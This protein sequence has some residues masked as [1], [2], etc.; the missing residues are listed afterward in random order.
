MVTEKSVKR[1]AD[2]LFY[3]NGE[4]RARASLINEIIKPDLVLCIHFNAAAEANPMQP[5]LVKNEHFHILLNGAFTENELAHDDERFECVLKILQGIHK[6]EAKMGAVAAN[7][8]HDAT[9]LPAY[10]YMDGSTRAVNVDNHPFLWA[11]NLIA[12]RLY[13]CPVL[14]YEPYL[15]NGLDSF[16]RLQ[17]GDYPG[18]RYVNGKLRVSIFREYVEAV[19]RGLVDYYTAGE[20][21]SVPD[22]KETSDGIKQKEQ[23]ETPAQEEGI[24]Q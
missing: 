12:N 20:V 16:K 10:A 2:K 3:R 5:T 11:R 19:T 23:A 17:A 18:L 22:T 15:M 24:E 4:I 9:T 13:Q 14:Y 21:Q 7:S 6:E 1:Q 8:F